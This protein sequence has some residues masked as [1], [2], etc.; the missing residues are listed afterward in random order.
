MKYWWWIKMQYEGPANVKLRVLTFSPQ[1]SRP[2][3]V[4]TDQNPLH[5][6]P[7]VRKVEKN[8]SLLSVISCIERCEKHQKLVSWD[9]SE[10]CRWS[11]SSVLLMMRVTD[12][13]LRAT[14]LHTL[15]S[16]WRVICQYRSVDKN[17][18]SKFEISLKLRID[19]SGL[20]MWQFLSCSLGHWARCLKYRKPSLLFEEPSKPSTILRSHISCICPPVIIA[21]RHCFN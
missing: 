14:C 11:C 21:G 15:L 6:N 10:S 1:S 13:I 5:N 9:H 8:N 20:A 19:R 16:S 2:F 12:P 17:T 18:R 4:V 3:D 7:I